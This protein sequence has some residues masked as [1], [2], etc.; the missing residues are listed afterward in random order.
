MTD[1]EQ[2]RWVAV[3]GVVAFAAVFVASLI[4]DE[5]I[6]NAYALGLGSGVGTMILLG[7]ATRFWSGARVKDAGV[8][9]GGTVSLEDAAEAARK[10]IAV[11][12]D[13]VNAQMVKINDRLGALEAELLK[14]EAAQTDNE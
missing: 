4:Q 13:R 10:P 5:K 7:V 11:L 8:P 14:G 1:L 2:A 3:L 6:A 9:G 12:E